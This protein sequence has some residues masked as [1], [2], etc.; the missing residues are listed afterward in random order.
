MLMKYRMNGV[1]QVRLP[2]SSHSV[3]HVSG[4]SGILDPVAV[5]SQPQQLVAEQ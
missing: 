3:G 4:N 5:Y 2:E 1:I